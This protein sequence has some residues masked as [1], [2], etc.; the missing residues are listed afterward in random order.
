[1]KKRNPQ[2][3]RW[4]RLDN[5]GK[6]FPLIANEKLSNVFRVSAVLKEPVDSELLQQALDTVLPRFKAFQVKLKR[7]FFWYYFEENKRRFLVEPEVDWP[8]RYIDPKSSELYLFR[9]SFFGARINLEIFHALTDGMGAVN[10]LRE[11]VCCY[12]R[13]KRGETAEHAFSPGT[14]KEQREL[15]EDSYLKNYRKLPKK[16]Y[17]FHPAYRLKGP[18][19]PLGE[20]SVIHG[21]V[22]L[23]ELKAVCRSRNVSI[24]K[25]LTACLIWAI[26]REHM[27]QKPGKRPI[28]INLPI[29]LR[30]FFGSSTNSNFFAVTSIEY[31]AEAAEEGRDSFEAILEAVSRQMDEKIVKEKLEEI[32]SYNV[33]NEKKWYIRIV[34]LFV[35]WLALGMIFRRH[36]RAQ[37]TTLSNIGL[38]S[39]DG[40]CRDEVETFQMM[41]GVSWRQPFKCGVCAYGERVVVSFSSVFRDS[42]VQD[43]FFERLR[44]DGI[45]V[46]EESNGAVKPE[47][48]KGNYPPPYYGHDSWR[49]GRRAN[50]GKSLLFQTIGAAALLV[51]LDLLTG[52]KGWSLNYGIP[53]TILFADWAVLGLM[54]VNRMNWQSYFMYQIGVTLLSLI[55]LVLWA[56]GLITRPLLTLV[57][58]AM[59]VWVFMG[60]VVGGKRRVRSELARR[61]HV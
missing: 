31:G 19:L 51:A 17:S 57:T 15:T 35:K 24:T 3:R 33:S 5:T 41:I 30:S 37:T 11:L 14:A 4:R 6:L 16:R 55:P 10:F 18:V 43:C 45:S 32:I 2:G 34:P 52:F 36:D 54:I 53:V 22:D 47:L 20:M 56:V 8:C 38:L 58:V 48:D 59:T 27:G 49:K 21:Y 1:M 60:T 42:R 50:L 12:L 40:D 29:N 25:Y 61:F 46:E 23:Q 28:S 7:G 13:L 39:V 26:Y 44:G 9:V